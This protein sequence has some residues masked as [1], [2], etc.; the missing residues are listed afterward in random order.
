M[1]KNTNPKNLKIF[2][3]KLISVCIAVIITI[4]ALFNILISGRFA[5]I[6]QILSLSEL[7]NRREY[8]NKLREELNDALEKDNLIKK[9]DRVLIY[10]LY[11][12]LKSEFKDIN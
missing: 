11:Q 2:F 3:I 1:D 5:Q 7:E 10:K 8:G 12:K 4:N 6:E 9:E